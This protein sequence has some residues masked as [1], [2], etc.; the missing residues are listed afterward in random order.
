MSRFDPEL[1]IQVR[2]A[3][4]RSYAE[5][6]YNLVNG[7]FEA[8]G[9]LVNVN[10]V[11]L[12]EASG[13]AFS[14]PTGPVSAGTDPASGLFINRSMVLL[15]STYFIADI[16]PEQFGADGTV[17][18]DTAALL[19]CMEVAL[20]A[21]SRITLS[22]MYAIDQSLSCY[23]VQTH[24]KGFT[25]HAKNSNCGIDWVGP[26]S[27]TPKYV[28]DVHGYNA[29]ITGGVRVQ[30]SSGATS[31]NT[32]IR[33]CGEG[34]IV[35]K[36]VVRGRFKRGVLAIACLKGSKIDDPD[37]Q[38]MPNLTAPALCE[39]VGVA[40][41]S[42]VNFT[43]H[44]GV[45]NY[46]E[47]P[48]TTGDLYESPNALK[49]P[50][51]TS[52]ITWGCEGVD[53]VSMKSILSKR[54][55]IFQGLEIQSVNCTWDLIYDN[56][57]SFDGS[58]LKVIGSWFGADRST[59]A[60]AKVFTKLSVGGAYVNFDGNTVSLGAS[61]AAVTPTTI[62]AFFSYPYSSFNGNTVEKFSCTVSGSNQITAI[63]NT[64]TIGGTPDVELVNSSAYNVFIPTRRKSRLSEGL[65]L[66]KSTPD[67]DG[68]LQI[69]ID[70]GE[71]GFNML[72]AAGPVLSTCP[73]GLAVSTVSPNS[74]AILFVGAR[75]SSGRSLNAVGTV[76]AS[77]SDYAEYV[78]KSAGCGDI[79]KGQIVGITN[80][81]EITDKFDE[82]ISFAIK[83]TEPS[84]VGGDTWGNS[85]NHP[86]AP[87][88]ASPVDFITP[89]RRFGQTDEQYAS[90]LEEASAKHAEELRLY[91]EAAAQYQKEIEAYSI[92]Y[93]AERV[94]YDRIAF[95]GQVPCNVFGASAGDYIIPT[96]GDN[97]LIFGTP[98]AN[99]SFEQY[100]QAVGIVWRLMDDG[101]C[102]VAVKIS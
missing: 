94:K 7:S 34:V 39:G 41:V 24:N 67:G 81:A 32:A 63:G 55:P 4:R 53:V 3:L 26:V 48:F 51:L 52:N 93:E 99:P 92:L 59:P 100:R 2:E 14:G 96:K 46:T 86:V 36:P 42:C 28:I 49:P 72:T 88:I 83:S 85:L 50:S 91:E 75:S 1:R 43:V 17:V 37:V 95:S 10:D 21:P 70:S 23:Y 80:R 74:E 30:E 78:L 29:Q 25:L 15:R 66:G 19:K 56:F 98:V 38:F 22:R 18:G 82:A 12:H 69:R 54:G 68:K 57:V 89:T 79:A 64:A 84:M 90:I 58:Y 11:L 61:L 35:E 71:R 5:A 76:N 73:G 44:K 33:V 77:G 45:A 20:S 62:S 60:T 31:I 47:S 65:I 16:T 8:G 97:G 40:V 27:A 101:R 6:G 13:K 102:L 9:A 87:D